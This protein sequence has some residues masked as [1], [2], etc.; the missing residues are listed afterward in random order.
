MKAICKTQ[1]DV[2][3][4]VCEVPEP[5]IGEQEVLIR[6]VRS[7][8]CGTDLHIY[9]WDSWAQSRLEPPVIVGHEFCGYV[10]AVGSEVSHVRV[11]DF[12]A[13]ESHIVCG[14]CTPCRLGQAHVC[15]NTQHSRRGYG[16]GLRALC[17]HPRRERL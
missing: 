5:T 10:A 3:L 9:Q 15:V 11:G 14:H 8:I 2:G 12:V 7:S 17:R 6:V 1:P 16:R 13:A 4:A